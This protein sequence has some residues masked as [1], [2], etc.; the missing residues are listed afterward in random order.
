[1]S[2]PGTIAF[3][4]QS[5]YTEISTSTMS[6]ALTVPAAVQANDV[7]I[8]NVFAGDY[9][10]SSL[11]NVTAPQGWTF[12]K[13]VTHGTAGLLQIY[14]RVANATDH[15]TTYSW[16]T[17]IWVGAASSLVAYSG[18]NTASPVDASAIQDNPNAASSYSTPQVTTSAA[19]D[20]LVATYASYS[21]N[22]VSSWN[23]PAGMTQRVNVNNGHLLSISN[24]D[25]TQSGAGASGTFSSTATPSQTYALT[26][27]VALRPSSAPAPITFRAQSTY[28]E[29]S[30]STM[31]IDLIVPAAVQANDV[32]IANVFAGDYLGSSLPVVTAPQGWTFV[33]QVTH[34]TAGLL[35]IYSRVASATDHGTTYS[36][37]TDIWVGAASSLVAYSG[38]NA[39]TPVDASAIQDNPS[40]AATYS[41]PQVT[42]SAASDL[43]VATY[44]SYSQNG[45][46]SWNAPA[47][48]TQRVNVN[49]G[50]LLSISNDDKIQAAAGASGTFSSTATPSQTYALTALVALKP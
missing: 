15:G 50:H 37:T 9:L 39:V 29:I 44:A 40:A 16:T 25:T 5:T 4:A 43:L 27:L 21:Q 10:G 34:G 26:A 22:G 12:V 7:L 20:L 14:S 3:R 33:K 49:N 11:P 36:W 8:A 23:A 32:L 38:A 28:T 48:M 30:T 35:Q 6:I 2:V 13:Q 31:S 17:D 1:V 46:S 42:T 18:V 24:D 45:V 19:G 41:T 47:G